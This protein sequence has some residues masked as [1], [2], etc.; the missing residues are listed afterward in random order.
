MMAIHAERGPTGR[1]RHGE[2]APDQGD[3]RDR[4]SK[5]APR[6]REDD[7]GNRRVRETDH[8]V[9]QDPGRASGSGRHDPLAG[10][11]EAREEERVDAG[12]VVP[13]AATTA[14]QATKTRIVSATRI[15]TLRML[16][17]PRR[18]QRDPPRSTR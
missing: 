15:S 4:R 11:A 14:Y 6:E 7:E 16:P 17:V 1:D 13:A 9:S 10:H 18:P 2:I 5:G 8:R 12:I 3:E